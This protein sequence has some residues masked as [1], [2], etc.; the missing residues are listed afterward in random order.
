MRNL[1]TI[2]IPALV[3]AAF[4][5]MGTC[6]GQTEWQSRKLTSRS[7]RR[8]NRELDSEIDVSMRRSSRRR[9]SGRCRRSKKPNGIFTGLRVG[10]SVSVKDEGS[11]FTITFFE[12]ELQQSHKIIEIGDNF[13]VVRD[14]AE[15]TETTIPIYSIKGIVKV[16]TKTQ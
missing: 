5:N 13:I 7:R 6:L 4:P 9:S 15:I 12:P 2:L 8:S 3:Q 10:H 14:I 1:S 11:A 16:R